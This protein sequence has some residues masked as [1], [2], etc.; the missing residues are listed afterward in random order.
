MFCSLYLQIKVNYFI[1]VTRE[2]KQY[3]DHLEKPREK[4]AKEDDDAFLNKVVMSLISVR[5]LEIQVVRAA[6]LFVL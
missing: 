6:I 4:D 2:V 3:L 1:Q 5:R